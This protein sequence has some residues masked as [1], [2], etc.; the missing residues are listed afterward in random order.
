[1]AKWSDVA[2]VAGVAW[3]MGAALLTTRTPRAMR[4]CVVGWAGVMCALAGRGQ[5]VPAAREGF[6][7]TALKYIMFSDLTAV[8]TH[9]Y[10]AR[11]SQHG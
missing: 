8:Y 11:S 5:H 3:N 10:A 1:M 2:R 6:F 4:V 7:L 9:V